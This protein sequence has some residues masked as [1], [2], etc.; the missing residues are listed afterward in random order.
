MASSKTIATANSSSF[1][2][3]SKKS[4][5]RQKAAKV[6][7]FIYECVLRSL[8][9]F[10][11]F[12]IYL[13]PPLFSE[14]R[15]VKPVPKNQC[16]NLLILVNTIFTINTTV[17]VLGAGRLFFTLESMNL[18]SLFHLQVAVFS[19]V[20]SCASW[21][22]FAHRSDVALLLNSFTGISKYFAL[23]LELPIK[24]LQWHFDPIVI[25]TCLSATV[26]STNLLAVQVATAWY[27]HTESSFYSLL[28]QHFYPE[29]AIWVKIFF[30]VLETLKLGVTLLLVFATGMFTVIP[31]A[32]MLIWLQNIKDQ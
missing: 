25:G 11:L 10:R 30:L 5:Q 15:C 19:C 2:C 6:T 29:L 28:V 17:Q 12:P 22:V 14:P 26:V 20:G 21:T 31:N 1:D 13:L 24:S 16:T 18:Q 27:Y 3:T 32:V 9:F 23:V 7:L 8:S 4:V